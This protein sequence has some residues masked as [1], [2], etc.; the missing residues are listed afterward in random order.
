[1]GSAG[2]WLP[3]PPRPVRHHLDLHIAVLQLPFV[4]L[5]EQHR[6]DQPDDRGLVGEDAD[7]VGAAFDFL[8]EPFE[9]VGAVQFTAVRLGKV[10]SRNA[11]SVSIRAAIC[12]CSADRA[13]K[14]TAT[15]RTN[16]DPANT[17]T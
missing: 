12:C 6:A 17:A 11:T 1:M 5:L 3:L 9:R 7:D 8:V 16:A 2:D 15:P 10:V 4:V 13:S 14:N